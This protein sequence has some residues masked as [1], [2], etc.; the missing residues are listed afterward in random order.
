MGK[1]EYEVMETPKN[2]G[3]KI[4]KGDRTIWD[5]YVRGHYVRTHNAPPSYEGYLFDKA[6]MTAIYQLEKKYY[7]H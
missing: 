4:T 3:M 2:H 6:K 1:N 5:V 7:K